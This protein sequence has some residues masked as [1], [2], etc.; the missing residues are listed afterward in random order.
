MVILIEVHE[1][2]QVRDAIKSTYAVTDQFGLGGEFSAALDVHRGDA[3]PDIGCAVCL[4]KLVHTGTGE[5][6]WVA[7]PMGTACALQG[8]C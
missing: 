6:E 3:H 4:P 5:D 1:Y 7:L 8:M 2:L